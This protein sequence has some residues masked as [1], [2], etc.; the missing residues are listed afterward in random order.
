M[1]NHR[2][3]H[4]NNMNPAEG[5]RIVEICEQLQM[6][7]D[8]KRFTELLSELNNVLDSHGDNVQ[9]QVSLPAKLDTQN[10]K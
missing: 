9:V 8:P 10:A 3:C 2:L 5:K 6:E 7:R 1:L 4:Q